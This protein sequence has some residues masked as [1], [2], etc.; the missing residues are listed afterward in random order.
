MG[1]G[2][3][4]Q[5]SRSNKPVLP[6]VRKVANRKTKNWSDCSSIC[7]YIRYLLN[8]LKSGTDTW[9]PVDDLLKFSN[10]IHLLSL[11]LPEGIKFSIFV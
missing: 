2:L 5:R 7:T 11:V 8:L 9:V 6:V 1:N 3:A 10:T 4:Y